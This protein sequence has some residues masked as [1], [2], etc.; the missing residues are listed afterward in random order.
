MSKNQRQSNLL[1]FFTRPPISQKEETTESPLKTPSQNEMKPSNFSY[2]ILIF[3]F[4]K[5]S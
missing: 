1:S 3:F 2:K 5:K 4:F